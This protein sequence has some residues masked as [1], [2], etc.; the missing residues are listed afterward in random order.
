MCCRMVSYHGGPLH[1]KY[2]IKITRIRMLVGPPGS[3]GRQQRYRGGGCMPNR[4]RVGPKRSWNPPSTRPRRRRTCTRSS[5]SRSPRSTR[6]A[7]GR[8][9]RP[10]STSRSRRSTRRANHSGPRRGR[11][12]CLGNCPSP[13]SKRSR[14]RRHSRPRRRRTRLRSSSSRSRRSTHNDRRS[15]LRRARRTRPCT[16]ASFRP[17]THVGDVSSCSHP[18]SLWR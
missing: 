17:T 16:R 12:T 3:S 2:T 7:S 18:K 9:T 11:R 15:C 5:S 4:P 1:V 8:R 6:S 10:S 14:S 13:L